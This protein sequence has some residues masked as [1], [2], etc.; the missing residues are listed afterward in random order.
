MI[1]RHY[2]SIK[3]IIKVRP[4]IQKGQ[5]KLLSHSLNENPQIV[6]STDFNAPIRDGKN[7]E[8][9]RAEGTRSSMHPPKIPLLFAATIPQFSLPQPQVHHD[10]LSSLRAQRTAQRQTLP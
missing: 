2:K 9:T 10:A 5:S 1:G 3:S 6:L 7:L 4:H 8:L